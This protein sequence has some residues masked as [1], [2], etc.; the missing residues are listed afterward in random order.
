MS[1]DAGSSKWITFRVKLCSDT[2]AFSTV[3]REELE[4]QFLKLLLEAG[5]SIHLGEHDYRLTEAYTVGR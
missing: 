4:E 2:D 5:P 1:G 3:P